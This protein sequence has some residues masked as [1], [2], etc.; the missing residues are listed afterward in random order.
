MLRCPYV[1]LQPGPFL[2]NPG[3]GGLVDELLEPLGVAVLFALG[4]A[5]AL[6]VLCLTGLIYM[7]VYPDGTNTNG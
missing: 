6:A 4:K 7:T 3:W 5:L 2:T 1:R